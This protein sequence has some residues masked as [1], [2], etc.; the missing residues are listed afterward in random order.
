MTVLR[1]YGEKPLHWWRDRCI[2][3]CYARSDNGLFGDQFYFE[4]LS[5]L[6]SEYVYIVVGDGRFLAPW[7]IDYYRYSDAILFHFHG[8]RLIAPH[9]FILSAYS[10]PIPVLTNIY[11]PYASLI[12]SFFL[13]YPELSRI[14]KPQAK[15]SLFICV[16][17]L[18]SWLRHLTQ[19]LLRCFPPNNFLKIDS[20]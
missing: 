16:H 7:N 17:M 12:S 2:D 1:D 19:K 14:F 15:I 4:Q 3:W 5:K 9:R 8:L 6:F 10:I 11:K 18:I 13:Q 20:I